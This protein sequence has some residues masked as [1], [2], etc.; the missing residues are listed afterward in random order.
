MRRSSL[1]GHTAELLERILISRQ[2]ADNVAREFFRTR[3]YLGSRDRRFIA[4]YLY[5]ILRHH[6]RLAFFL[7]RALAEVRP[8]VSIGRPPAIGF[9]A[10]YALHVLGEAEEALLPDVAGLWRMVTT[11]IDPAAFLRALAGSKIPDDILSDPCMR[12]A[13]AQSMP[14]FIVREWVER[15]GAVEAEALCVASNSPAPTAVRVNRLRTDPESCRQAL[16]REGVS[17][18]RGTL[19]PDALMLEKRCNLPGLRL[20]RDGWV[21]VQDEGSQLLALLLQAKP[22]D[23]VVDACAGAGGKTLHLGAIMENRGSILS[24]DVDNERL[25]SLRLRAA[26]AGV[27]IAEP[28]V[29]TREGVPLPSWEQGADAV[30][31][32]AP[33]S[34]VG[35]FRRNPG[36]KYLASGEIVQSLHAVQGGILR[37]AARYVRPGGRLVYS[38]C[39]L[40]RSENEQIVEEFL[41]GGEDFHLLP[42]PRLL[43]GIGVPIEGEGLTLALFPHRHFTD[44]FFAAVMERGN[45]R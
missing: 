43:R 12:I 17:V 22:G 26:R 30:L 39:S 29:T 14:E 21:E 5:G 38:T 20:Y 37:Q 28:C 27:T 8:D 36:A 45:S 24:L 25:K 44:G 13:L 32:D 41:S 23:R 7:R 16:V 6:D 2:P 33:C 35:T 10:A 42:A 40:L 4:D 15:Y 34:G 31:V 11:E 9:C 19:A 1:F 18:R 3:H